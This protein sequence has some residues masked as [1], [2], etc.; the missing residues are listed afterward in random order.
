[1]EDD[2]IWQL[3]LWD[4]KNQLHLPALQDC[5][6]TEEWK[7]FKKEEKDLKIHPSLL[8]RGRAVLEGHSSWCLPAGLAVVRCVVGLFP[9]PANV[10][11]ADHAPLG[12]DQ[13][14]LH[15]QRSSHGAPGT[16]PCLTCRPSEPTG[17]VQSQQEGSDALKVSQK[18]SRMKLQGSIALVQR[19]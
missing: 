2:W 4:S 11:L 8:S 6:T 16:Q 10:P 15:L 13:G 19:L 3:A 9:V 12:T 1:M 14:V 18:G 5:D 7:D 17:A